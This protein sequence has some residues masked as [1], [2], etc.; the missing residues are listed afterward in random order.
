M[1]KW[2]RI[3]A[4][5]PESLDNVR[6]SLKKQRLMVRDH[7][8]NGDTV[9]IACV[10]PEHQVWLSRVCGDFTANLV[11]LEGPPTGIREVKKTEY[12]CVCGEK[13]YDP[14]LYSNHTRYC[15]EAKA[16]RGAPEKKPPRE[17]VSTVA[18]L[19]PGEDFNLEGVISS[20]EAVRNR[21]QS[22]LE[23]VELILGNLQQYKDARVM[24]MELDAEV[25]GRVDAV[26]LLIRDERIK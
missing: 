6:K 18:K 21:L 9:L 23:L 19:E 7:T 8:H 22:N 25:K 4:T 11:K 12:T 3:T 10:N 26:K 14:L 2:Y 1:M 24:M 5:S 17:K 20:L 16:K 13:F 15:E